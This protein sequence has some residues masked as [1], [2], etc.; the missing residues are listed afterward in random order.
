MMKSI[1][2]VLLFLA[3][4]NFPACAGL[5]DNASSVSSDSKALGGQRRVVLNAGYTLHKITTPDGSI[6]KE[7]VSPRG[8]VFGVSWQGRS[9]PDLQQLLG[10]Y[11]KAV[12]EGQRTQVA[13]RRAIVIQTDDFVFFSSGHLRSF[14]GRAYVPSLIPRN[15]KSEVVK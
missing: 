8:I 5:G 13:R 7:F 15:V 10:S 12:R 6:V 11:M 2:T 4:E 3:V 9:M 1:L 14:Q